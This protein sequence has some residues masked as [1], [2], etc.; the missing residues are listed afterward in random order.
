MKKKTIKKW[1]YDFILSI[2]ILVVVVAAVIYSYILE[3]PRVTLFLARPD[4]YMGLWFGVLAILALMLMARAL[5]MRKT[6]EGQEPG[7]PIWSGLAV[8]TV[9]V[10]FVYLLTLKYLGFV[11][12]SFLML[13][14]LTAVY[15]F[16][17]GEKKKD[18]HDKKVLTV[19]LVKTC[20]FS[21]AASFATYYVFTHLL[22]SRLP[23]FSLF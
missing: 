12:G 23:A 16:N 10:M 21:L 1:M 11:L 4:T 18:W 13:W 17:I 6:P 8:Y 3:S 15:T 14:A 9:A 20:L 5:K 19:E 22:T 2:C 7:A